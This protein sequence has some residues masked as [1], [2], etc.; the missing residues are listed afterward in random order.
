MVVRPLNEGVTLEGDLQIWV[1]I[2][3]LLYAIVTPSCKASGV[4]Y[5]VDPP[6]TCVQGVLKKSLI[7]EFR[8]NKTTP[9]SL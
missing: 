4:H 9:F 3:T 7:G 8:A 1:N 2:G 5:M 6:M